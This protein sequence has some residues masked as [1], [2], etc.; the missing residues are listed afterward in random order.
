MTI[1]WA[2]I[3]GFLFGFVLQKAGATNPQNIIGML[4][5][6]NL[7]LAKAIMLAIGSSSLILFILVSL[8]LIDV[9]HFSIKS[10]YIGVIVGGV[11][12]GVGWAM[13]GYCPGTGVT[14]V[15][16]GRMSAI[17][18]VI[19]GLLGALLFTLAYSMLQDTFLFS[20]LFEGK[21]S[22]AVITEKE[23][24]PLLPQVSA[25]VVAGSIA[26]VFILAAFFLPEPQY[27]QHTD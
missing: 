24:V 9:S 7:H 25:L 26:L 27:E 10:S 11:I 22:L 3:L 14:A 21:A 17:F 20:S 16:A 13:A 6:Q 12:L 2:I 19:G 18:Y 1:I 23:S 4:R 8:N 5:L 15:G